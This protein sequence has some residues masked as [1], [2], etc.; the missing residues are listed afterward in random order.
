MDIIKKKFKS[1]FLILII[2][3]SIKTFYFMAFNNDYKID[4]NI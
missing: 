2:H 1:F 4:F 3:E